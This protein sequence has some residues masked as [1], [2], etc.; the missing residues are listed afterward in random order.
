MECNHYQNFYDGAMS[1]LALAYHVNTGAPV[2]TNSN[3]ML[4]TP[5]I[6]RCNV[7]NVKDDNIQHCVTEHF[8]SHFCWLSLIR[9][10]FV[11]VWRVLL[12]ALNLLL[13]C[14]IAIVGIVGP[15]LQVAPAHGGPP[16]VPRIVGVAHFGRSGR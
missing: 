9:K 3:K 12:S 10:Q 11:L 6:K 15:G 4:S 1:A 8:R 14:L 16:H 5:S 13:S 7:L 2:K